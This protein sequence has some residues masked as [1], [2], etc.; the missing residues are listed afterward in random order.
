M[1]VGVGVC[2]C[3]RAC[4]CECVHARVW[5]RVGACVG[6]PTLLY[7]MTKHLVEMKLKLTRISFPALLFHWSNGV[8]HTR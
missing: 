8:V 4:V 7:R 1:C 2:G 6:G 5:V 3:L